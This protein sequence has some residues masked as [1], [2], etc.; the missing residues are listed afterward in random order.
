MR[1]EPAL[2]IQRRH[3]SRASGR[4]G[5]AVDLVL[6]IAAREHAVDAGVRRARLDLDVALQARPPWA[7]P[8]T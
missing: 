3:A 5:L 1:L 7:K 4:D 2:G 6:D 8:S